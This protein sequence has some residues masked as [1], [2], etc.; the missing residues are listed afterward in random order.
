M[1]NLEE[2]K[3]LLIGMMITFLVLVLCQPVTAAVSLNIQDSN[4]TDKFVVTDSG[5]VGIGTSAPTRAIQITGTIANSAQILSQTVMESATG[6]GGFIGYH[7]RGTVGSI[8]LPS[9]GDRLGYYLFGS[10]DPFHPGRAI[11]SAG[12]TSRAESAWTSDG[13]NNISVPAAILFETTDVPIAPAVSA[14][15]EKMRITASG[16]VGIGTATPT[17]A[18]EVSGGIRSNPGATTVKPACN[19][20]DGPTTRGTFWFTNGGASADTIE[21]CIF[22]GT[23]YGWKAISYAP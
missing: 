23:T 9:A 12:I 17:Q 1:K 13:G 21:I 2:K 3:N 11:N 8:A 20:S 4:N 18:L 5:Y 16:K 7:N 6:G 15:T 10:F 19:N 14:R 22:N